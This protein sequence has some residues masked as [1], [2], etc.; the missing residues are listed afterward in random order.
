MKAIYKQIKILSAA[1]L[2]LIAHSAF[3]AEPLKR[4]GD[5]ARL[6]TLMSD[7]HPAVYLSNGET[8]TYGETPLV[9]YADSDNLKRWNT[10]SAEQAESVELI[11]IRVAD[12]KGESARLTASQL[13]SF[14]NLQYVV[15]LYEY[16]NPEDTAMAQ[17]ADAMVKLPN[18]SEAQLFWIVSIPQ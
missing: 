3:A 5:D 16:G 9:V 14:A 2:L 17:K 13:S 12:A 11:V 4:G 7:I 18:G 10:V 6:N 8:N 15:V 1:L